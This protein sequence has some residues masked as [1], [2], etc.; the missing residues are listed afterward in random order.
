[1]LILTSAS[2][3]AGRALLALALQ[4]DRLAVLDIGRQLD[5]DLA[6]V[7]K[8]RVDACGSRH[9]LDA[10]IERGVHIRRRSRPARPSAR[11]RP[12]AQGVA[13]N[14]AED[15]VGTAAAERIGAA[16]AC[17][18]RIARRPVR[19]CWRNAAN[20]S[21]LGRRLRNRGSCG[22]PSASIS[23]RSKAPGLS[24]R[25]GSHRPGWPRRTGPSP[26]GRPD[27]GPDDVSW[28]ACGRRT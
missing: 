23:P 15:V 9:V 8:H 7:G 18:T 28:R 26:S 19:R 3:G 21:P 2:P 10:D 16:A 22:L 11:Q 14:L 4:P 1:M 20:G 27:S 5:G 17:G 24:R 25:P 6:A 12:P 13:E